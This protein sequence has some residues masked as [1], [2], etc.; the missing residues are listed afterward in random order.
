MVKNTVVPARISLLAVTPSAFRPNKRSSIFSPHRAQTK[1]PEAVLPAFEFS[2]NLA[3]LVRSR[4]FMGWFDKVVCRRSHEIS[5]SIAMQQT[6]F[7][8]TKLGL[9]LTLI[10]LAAAPVQAA[11][12]A[13]PSKPDPLLD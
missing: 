9:R 5:R 4:S 7:Y 11:T 8:F 1:R 3:V 2:P 10:L 12:M 6:Q 13:H